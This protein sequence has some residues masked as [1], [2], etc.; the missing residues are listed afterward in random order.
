LREID[1][2]TAG[3]GPRR[4]WLT[5]C[6]S[7]AIGARSLVPRHVHITDSHLSPVDQQAAAFGGIAAIAVVGGLASRDGEVLKAHV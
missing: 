5:V 6:A 4:A 1:A 3:V 7:I 2:A